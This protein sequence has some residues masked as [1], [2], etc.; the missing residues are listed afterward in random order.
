M[1]E[2]LI[3]ICIAIMTITA[4]M[5]VQS[6]QDK[7]R[8]ISIIEQTTDLDG[9]PIGW[10]ERG[11]ATTEQVWEEIKRNQAIIDSY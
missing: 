5:G 9:Y 11:W 4:I 2:T 1:K 7:S 6:C 3:T 8:N 10:E